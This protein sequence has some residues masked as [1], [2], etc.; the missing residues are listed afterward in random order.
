MDILFTALKVLDKITNEKKVFSIA[1][2]DCCKNKVGGDNRSTV[3]TL[4][5]CALRH[6]LVLKY[7]FSSLEE[8]DNKYLNSCILVASNL[9][10]AKKISEKESFAFLRGQIEDEN[11]YNKAKKL[12]DSFVNGTPLIPEACDPN[13]LEYLSFRYNTPLWIVKMWRKHYGYKA[14]RNTLIAN[15]K[16]FNNY[17]RVN[18]EYINDERFEIEHGNQFSKTDFEHFYVFNEKTGIKKT[19]AFIDKKIYVC[20]IAFEEMVKEGDADTFRGIAAFAATPNNLLSA[21]AANLTSYVEADMIVGK[22]QAYFEIKR[23]KEHYNL[24]N[25]HLYEGT[26]ESLITC[27]SKKVHTMFVIPDSSNFFLLRNTPDYF[28]RFDQNS[29]DEII[30]NQEKALDE[31]SKFVED[32]GY[33]VYAVATLSEK[34]TRGMI[35]KFLGAHKEFRLV[36]ENLIFPFTHY[37]TSMYYAV[38]RKVATPND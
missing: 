22:Q 33:L 1:V 17:A 10:F 27:V 12:I 34:E 19:L 28:I 24:K 6:Y 7:R 20:P 26:P 11:H 35:N 37:D 32:D 16:H 25:V 21:L 9:L 14:M 5:G 13:G 23:E 2:N 36:K 30:A 15:S 29:L 31:S 4:V 18:A 38:L 3:T 8:F